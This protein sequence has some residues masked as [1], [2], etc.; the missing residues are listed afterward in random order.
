[1]KKLIYMILISF[2]LF[3]CSENITEVQNKLSELNKKPVNPDPEPEL[4]FPDLDVNQKY[5]AGVV[6]G[7]IYLWETQTFTII[8]SYKSAALLPKVGLSD[9]NNDG[10][11]E[12]I[13]VERL[14]GGRGKDKYE[15]YNFSIFQ[16]GDSEP[17]RTPIGYFNTYYD[18]IWDMK[19][20]NMDN[21]PDDDE[22]VLVR[23]DKIEVYE[24][25]DLSTPSAILK[26][27]HNIESVFPWE[28]EI[29]NNNA[30]GI[31]VAFTD[32]T[33]KKFSYDEN[34]ITMEEEFLTLE[35]DGLNIAKVLDLDNDGQ[36]EI[37]AGGQNEK[38]HI[39]DGSSYESFTLEGSQYTW[40]LDVD[41]NNNIFIGTSNDGVH[42]LNYNGVNL[43]YTGKVIDIENVQL[44]GL[45]VLNSSILLATDTGLK[46]YDASYNSIAVENQ[47][48]GFLEE[49]ICQ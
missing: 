11:K 21:N 41:V 13:L 3:S 17:A 29:Y 49:L 25:E 19:I 4:V 30:N 8:W 40:A 45:N 14:K 1:M 42:L 37:I 22:I 38:I 12:L 15:E 33:C 35:G 46:V 16:K 23:R 31:I 27:T 6:D 2:F 9:I 36:S 24:L 28:G 10:F 20:G 34:I 39:W 18:A 48:I 43:N 7:T 26:F 47:T 32:G 5:V 44:N